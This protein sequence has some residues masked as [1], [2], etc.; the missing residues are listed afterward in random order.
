MADW[1]DGADLAGLSRSGNLLQKLGYDA[2]E[3]RMNPDLRAELMNKVAG[4]YAAQPVQ[5]A[6]NTRPARPSAPPMA[7]AATADGP[8][9]PAQPSTGTIPNPTS[10][11]GNMLPP[12]LAN[13][14]QPTIPAPARSVPSTLNVPMPTQQSVAGEAAPTSAAVSPTGTAAPSPDVSNARTAAGKL[15]ADEPALPDTTAQDSMIAAKSIPINPRQ[16]LYKEGTGG[17]IGREFKAGAV[18]FLKGGVPGAVAGFV[19]PHSVGE[20]A[21]SDPNSGYGLDEQ[22]R[23]YQLALAQ[24]QKGD[25]MAK[26]KTMAD[27]RKQQDAA[28]KDAGEIA[29]NTADLPN[30]KTTADADM[31]RAQDAGQPKTIDAAIAAFNKETDP[32]KKAILGH[33]VDQMVQAAK[34]IRPPRETPPPSAALV[35][36]SDWKRSLGHTPTTDE[37]LEY[38]RRTGAIDPNAP[39]EAGAIVAQAMD[40]KEKF[41]SQWQDDGKGGYISTDPTNAKTLT[42][43]AFQSQINKLG[44]EDPNVKLAKKGYQID[45]TGQMV[46][47]HPKPDASTPAAPAPPKVGEVRQGFRFKGGDP[48]DQANWTKVNNARSRR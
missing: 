43:A 27:L 20:A 5:M 38:G 31:L 15:L 26:F 46:R 23:Q 9:R 29:N 16:K 1:A 11:N 40:A 12:G 10:Q 33:T 3:V 39:D 34:D 13:R 45:E 36:Y 22:T 47:T 41:A 14:Q 17:K 48:S 21:P 35:E 2:D 4:P 19:D 37:V 24:K 25:A 6:Q 8:P 28:S 32:D 30:K 42:G 44:R 7:P 18:G